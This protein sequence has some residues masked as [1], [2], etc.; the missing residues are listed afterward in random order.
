MLPS[1]ADT[2]AW[3][4]VDGALDVRRRKVVHHHSLVQRVKVFKKRQKM[5]IRV[6]LSCIKCSAFV[7]LFSEGHKGCKRGTSL[8]PG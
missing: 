4:V 5:V 2:V 1:F 8:Q 3:G 6:R 7:P